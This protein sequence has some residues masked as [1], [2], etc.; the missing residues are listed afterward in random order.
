VTILD[1]YA[2]MNLR[3]TRGD[4]MKYYRLDYFYNRRDSGSYF[5]K[6]E[7]KFKNEEEIILEAENKGIIEDCDS[8]FQVEEIDKIEYECALNIQ[9][10]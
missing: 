8:I 10:E 7:L 9:P 1:Q 6:S 5:F 4:K 2:T 3:V